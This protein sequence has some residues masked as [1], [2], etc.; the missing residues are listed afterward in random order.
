M[1]FAVSTLTKLARTSNLGRDSE[2]VFFGGNVRAYPF[3]TNR[4]SR[5][6]TI[7]PRHARGRRA[8][9]RCVLH[10]AHPPHYGDLYIQKLFR[11][12]WSRHLP[13]NVLRELGKLELRLRTSP[14]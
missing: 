8:T 6:S 2:D 4:V 7:V 10:L 3:L 14:R 1:R 13:R 9:L 5:I 12:V 11:T